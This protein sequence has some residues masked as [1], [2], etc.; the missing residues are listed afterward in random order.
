M[1]DT[2]QVRLP[3]KLKKDALK[4]SAEKRGGLS[5]VVRKLCTAWLKSQRLRVNVGQRL[6]RKKP[7]LLKK[8][9]F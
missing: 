8:P 7:G 9:G 3:A 2:L 4:A 6:T 5:Q 1:N